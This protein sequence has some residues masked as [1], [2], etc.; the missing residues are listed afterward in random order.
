MVKVHPQNYHH[1][2]EGGGAEDERA[3]GLG[4][5]DGANVLL[6]DGVS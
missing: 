4:P 3:T 5:L 1:V 6:F 2:C